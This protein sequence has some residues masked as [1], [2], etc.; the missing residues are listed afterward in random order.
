MADRPHSVAGLARDGAVGFD[1]AVPCQVFGGTRLLDGHRATTHW[2]LAD[3]E[4]GLRWKLEYPSA[5]RAR[6]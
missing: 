1:R 5:R 2:W 6:R 4:P 3:S